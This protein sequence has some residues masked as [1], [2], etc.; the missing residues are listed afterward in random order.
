MN[1]KIKKIKKKISSY[2]RFSF[3]KI[4]I[5]PSDID[6]DALPIINITFLLIRFIVIK[7]INEQATKMLAIIK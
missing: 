5:N 7:G 3:T 2:A 4:P 6:I 1:A